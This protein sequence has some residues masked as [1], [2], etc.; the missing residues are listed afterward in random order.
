MVAHEVR[1]ALLPVQHALKKIWAS[2]A[3]ASG[4]LAEPRRLVDEG[5]ARRHRF[6]DDS[7]R[8]T[9]LASE[10]STSF[11]VMEVIDEARRR[12]EP[13]PEGGIRI[14]AIPASA[15]PRC[16]GHRGRLVLAILNILRNSMQVGGAGV[17]IAISVDARDSETVLVR[18]RDDIEGLGPSYQGISW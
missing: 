17:R 9:P 12:C 14:E 3:I 10:E 11:P 7:V 16:Q 6:V 1:N 5:L 8:P 15:D 13:A 18:I 4:D 2:P